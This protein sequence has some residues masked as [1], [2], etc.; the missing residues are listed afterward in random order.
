[1]HYDGQL[2]DDARLVIAL[3]R[4]AAGFGARVITYARVLELTGDAARARDERTG[5]EFTVRARAV[6][7][8]A[9]GVG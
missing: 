3:A 8:A 7:N 2:T 4:T 9:G 1:M 5:D 6:V